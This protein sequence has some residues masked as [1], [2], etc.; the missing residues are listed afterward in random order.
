[1]TAENRSPNAAKLLSQAI[2]FPCDAQSA[3]VR[4]YFRKPLILLGVAC[5]AQT[6]PYPLCARARL[7]A[8]RVRSLGGA[9]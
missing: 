2:D 3:K 4:I 8:A 6:P 7:M 5:E 1:M 9:P